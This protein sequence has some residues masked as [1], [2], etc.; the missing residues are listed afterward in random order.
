[1]DYEKSLKFVLEDERWVTKL[2]IG[3]GL[4]LVSTL[5][6]VILVGI[7]G[8]FI[9]GGYCIRLLQNVRDGNPRPLPEWDRWGEDFVAGIKVAV[10]F[11]IYMIPV[12]VFLI[13]VMMGAFL[14]NVNED[15]AGVAMAL[16]ACSG[17]LVA[18]YAIA[19]S[20]AQPGIFVE[21]AR[22]NSI[23][24][25]LNVRSVFDWTHMRLG[26]VIIVTIVVWALS[27]VI[28]VIAS[29]AG[30]ILLVIGLIITIPLGVLV[31]ELI[32][33]HLYGQLARQGIPGTEP[34]SP[35]A[36]APYP[37]YTQQP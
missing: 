4:I 31:T 6:S 2:S 5:L 10:V 33:F 9:L 1:M 14:A 28:S 11:L 12:F 20:L 17:C 22:R 29:V 18:I 26:N 30:M 34:V 36:P 21:F 16:M 23:G 7:L 25:G 13:P 3:V 15:A 27:S 8:F 32:T 35:V 37:T 19:L 24:D